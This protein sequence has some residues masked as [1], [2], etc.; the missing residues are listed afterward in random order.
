MGWR[1]LP[2][3]ELPQGG[4]GWGRVRVET[5]HTERLGLG[6]GPEQRHNTQELLPPPQQT[7]MAARGMFCPHAARSVLP[8]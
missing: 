7:H 3:P 6:G 4:W 5:Q 8:P 1:G 2:Q